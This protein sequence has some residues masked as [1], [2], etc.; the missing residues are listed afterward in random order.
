MLPVAFIN[1]LLRYSLS[2]LTL[3]FRTR[4]TKYLYNLYMRGYV[5]STVFELLFIFSPTGLCSIVLATWITAFPM[6]INY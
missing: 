1:S 6:L 4:L 3:R 5:H 2:E